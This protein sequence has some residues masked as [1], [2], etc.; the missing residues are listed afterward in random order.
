TSQPSLLVVSGD[1]DSPIAISPALDAFD[2]FLS[3]RDYEGMT[4]YLLDL[5]PGFMHSG[6]SHRPAVFPQRFHHTMTRVS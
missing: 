3:R 6:I 4:E 5:F 2:D 1:P